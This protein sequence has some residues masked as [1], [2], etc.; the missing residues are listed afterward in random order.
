MHAPDSLHTHTHACAHTQVL[1]ERGLE[2]HPRNTRI[3][4]AYAAFE[5]DPGGDVRMAQLL[6][7][8][9]AAVEKHSITD[10]HNR[11]ARLR[12]RERLGAQ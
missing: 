5:L 2:Y 10:M 6:Y 4:A 7:K 12:A 1:F 8:R 9:S 3:M 11:W